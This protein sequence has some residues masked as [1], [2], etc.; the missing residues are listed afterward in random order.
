ML[1]LWLLVALWYH[2]LHKIFTIMVSSEQLILQVNR[3]AAAA[4]QQQT[5]KYS[6]ESYI[7]HPERVMKTCKVYLNET[8]VLC[9]ALLHD[10]LEDTPITY[11]DLRI[12]LMTVMDQPTALQTLKIVDELTDKFT[13]SDYPR[14][15]RRLRREKEANR[16]AQVSSEAQTIK[17]ADIIDNTDVAQHDPD[18]ARVYLK[19]ASAVLQLMDKGNAELRAIAIETVNECLNRLTSHHNVR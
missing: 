15:N 14:L 19:E 16:L 12:F 8:A 10:V 17:Y 2:N 1:Y 5:R 9:G 11:D 6:D 13:K 7:V 3:F 4:H 18:F